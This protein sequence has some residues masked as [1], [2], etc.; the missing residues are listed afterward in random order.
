MA[1]G[2]GD[3]PGIGGEGDGG[4]AGEDVVELA[5]AV[6]IAIDDAD[7][8]AHAERDFGGVGA[9]YASAEDDDVGGG[10][11]GDAAEEQAAAA[12]RPFEILGA[13][14]DGHAPGDFAHGR[15]QG[16]R[17]VVFD[18]GFVGDAGGLGGEQL[19]GE[20]GQRRQVQIGEQ[21]EAGPEVI[22]FGGL[23]LFDFDDEIGL[24]PDV[25]GI[26]ENAWHRQ[27]R[28]RY[29]AWRCLRR[30]WIERELHGQ[31]RVER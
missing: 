2:F 10:D 17:A 27:L 4:A 9:D 26:G 23:R 28:S 18:D 12:V 22:V 24:A 3:G 11:A 19:L 13:D 25:G 14:L 31:L 20:L 8:G 7:V 6:E 16:E 5:Q 30:R 15:E 29:R 21:G 1:Q